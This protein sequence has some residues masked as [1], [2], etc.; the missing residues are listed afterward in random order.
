M[1]QVSIHPT[2][3]V[4]EGA[5]IGPGTQVWH[6]SHVMAGA[7]IGQECRLGQNV[8]VGKGVSV[9]NRVKIQNNVSVYAGVT[10]EDDVFC[11]P[12]AVFTNVRDPRSAF[13]KIPSEEFLTTRVGRGA[14]IGAN[15]TIICGVTIGEQAF[16]GAGAVVTRD[17]PRFA[18]VWGNPARLRGWMCCCG[19][20]LPLSPTSSHSR[21]R[22][23]RCDRRFE[24]N[25]QEITE[26]TE[27]RPRPSGSGETRLREQRS[28][29]SGA[30]QA[31]SRTAR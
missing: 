20:H 12:S 31:A 29:R 26:V 3:V 16:I 22:C 21:G 8:F 10:L 1:S 11:G 28:R 5:V 2:A 23:P 6:F 9:G 25:G 27:G 13:P 15:A 24:Q 7:R 17:V 4:D 30:V 14:T 19:E 18:L